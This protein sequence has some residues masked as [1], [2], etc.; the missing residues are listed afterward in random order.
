MRNNLSR[1]VY[2]HLTSPEISNS[3]RKIGFPQTSIFELDYDET[4]VFTASELME[5]VPHQVYVYREGP[6]FIAE[7]T[8][9]KGLKLRADTLPD[10]IGLL[11]IRIHEMNPKLLRGG[12]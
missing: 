3:L 9:G 6:S 5:Y 7:W 12:F 8:N 11:I 4:C 2:K 10:A 1:R